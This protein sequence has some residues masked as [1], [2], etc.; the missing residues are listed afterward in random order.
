M[1]SMMLSASRAYTTRE[2]CNLWLFFYAPT[3]GVQASTR[4]YWIACC[5]SGTLHKVRAV[6]NL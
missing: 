3:L 2:G 6:Q 1:S 4:D 5:K